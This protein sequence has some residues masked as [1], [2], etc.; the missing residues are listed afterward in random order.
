MAQLIVDHME[1][2]GTCFLRGCVPVKVESGN[3]RRLSVTWRSIG[4]ESSSNSEEFDTVLFATGG[5]ILASLLS[6]LLL[7]I[8]FASGVLHST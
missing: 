7:Y 4:D 8:F 1:R 5:H 6:F 3:D 2:Y